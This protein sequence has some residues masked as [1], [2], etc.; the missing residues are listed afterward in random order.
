M[1][2]DYCFWYGSKAKGTAANKGSSA[3]NAF[4]Q[5][6]QTE[7][8][9][10]GDNLSNATVNEDIDLEEESEHGPTYDESNQKGIRAFFASDSTPPMTE[11]KAYY[12]DLW[13][14]TSASPLQPFQSFHHDGTARVCA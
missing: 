11:W 8:A 9:L 4:S 14:I 5:R 12:T 3:A 13:G 6:S 10:F 7:N 2:D 1:R